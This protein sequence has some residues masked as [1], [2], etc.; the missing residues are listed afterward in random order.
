MAHK[1]RINYGI[2]APG[3]GLAILI[4]VTGL[5]VTSV[6]FRSSVNPVEQAISSMGFSLAPTG[7]L[8][9]ML[10]V[11]YMKVEKFRHRDR[12]L[13]MLAWK[14]DEQVLDIGTGRG[15][16]MIGAAKRLT[17][18]KSYG[19]DIWNKAD[20]SNNTYEAAMHNAGLE[21]VK[22]KVEIINADVQSMPF[23]DNSFDFVLS[24]LCIHNIKSK[25]GR[26]AACREIVRVLK[27]GGTALI[28]DFMYTGE[29]EAE[30]EKLGLETSSKF[31]FLVAPVLLG[32]VRAEKKI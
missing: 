30:F 32:I 31:S 14:G 25:E 19:I 8:I 16:L 23:S 2:D 13:N 18:G 28:S 27:P 1:P 7:I 26:A 22:Q 3:L 11:L 20:L 9:I 10:I 5:I 6:L 17:T 15:L 24:N 21:G 4:I 12:M 29:Y